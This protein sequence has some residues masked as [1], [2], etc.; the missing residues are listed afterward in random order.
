M[1]SSQTPE[2]PE[3]AHRMVAAVP[4]VE[5]A[6]DRDA[7]RGGR[8]DRERHARHA[9]QVA[10]VGAE[11]V[12][13]PVL[14]AL[15]EEVEVLVAQRRQEAVGVAELPDPPVAPRSRAARRRTPRSRFGMKTSKSPSGA[16]RFIGKAAG[17]FSP[18]RTTSQDGGVAQERPHHQAAD[19]AVGARMHPED[20][21]G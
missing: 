2:A 13:D 6:D 20:G 5:V 21:M 7:G 1:K 16:S 10:Q 17:G 19:A 11:L 18:V 9:A 8:P 12:V 14:V 15:V 3:A 4:A